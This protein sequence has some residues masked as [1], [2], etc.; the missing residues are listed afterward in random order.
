MSEWNRIAPA[1]V[2]SRLIV[3]EREHSASLLLSYPG[4]RGP[5]SPLGGAPTSYPGLFHAP[6]R[7]G[8]LA[9]AL[10]V[11]ADARPSSPPSRIIDPAVTILP[12]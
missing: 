1:R 3:G 9:W 11:G 6:K 2:S 12:R 4:R 7:F 10:N 8:F 5:T